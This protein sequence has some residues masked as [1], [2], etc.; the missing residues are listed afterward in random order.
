MP[1]PNYKRSDFSLSKNEIEWLIACRDIAV[2]VSF[3][4]EEESGLY[5]SPKQGFAIE[6]QTMIAQEAVSLAAEV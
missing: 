5:K 4:K 2:D 1:R 3:R 6:K